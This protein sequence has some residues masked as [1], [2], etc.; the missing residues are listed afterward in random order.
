MSDATGDKPFI[1]N[2]TEIATT[3][4]R[5][6]AMSILEI[7]HETVMT[8]RVLREQL[9][10]E[11]DNIC[12]GWDHVCLSDYDRVF[13][14]AVGKCA[15]DAAKV[16]ED[17]LG[18]R[19]SDGV[20]LDVKDGIFK[21]LRS[22]AGSHP[23]PSEENIGAT[24]VI[25]DMLKGLTERDLVLTV[26]SGGGSSL[27]C[28]PHEIECESLELI[29]KELWHHGANIKE[30]NTVRKHLS[31]IQGGQLA[32]IAYPAHIV[33]F[34]FSDVPGNDVSVV[35]SG[36]TVLDLT[37]VDD[38]AKILAKYDVLKACRLANCNLVETPKDPKYFEHVKNLLVVTNEMA[39]NAMRK[40][41]E[42]LGYNAR[43]ASFSIAGNARDL[44]TELATMEL[45]RRA[46]VIYGGETTVQVRGN[47]RGGRNQELTLA[48]ARAISDHRVVAA[49][50]SDGWDNT[51]AAGAI[52]D[53][54]DRKRAQEAGVIID[55]YLA[56]ND[57]YNFW[58][59][60]GG[61]MRTGRTGIN[62][63]DFYMVL[64]E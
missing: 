23:F 47:G 38:A 20:V 18:E 33:S 16:L 39:L 36:P 11:G 28:M 60:C 52:A 46:C 25:V 5:R 64:T 50:A 12:F 51:D 1:Q 53:A 58:K 4:L 26:I 21:R 3:Q 29:T 35:A 43:V 17:I 7:G 45:P 54:G 24:Q 56:T 42:G 10:M 2:W 30:V 49:L 22:Y 40:H 37:T 31:D 13:V 32:K 14:I 61:A 59:K 15:V 55:D 19:V 9:R 48:A 27:L 62:V 41:A 34:I 8:G 57:S 63:A 44:G 6:D